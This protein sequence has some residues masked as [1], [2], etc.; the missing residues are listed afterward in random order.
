MQKL[1]ITLGVNGAVETSVFLSSVN[2]SVDV[3]IIAD[4]RCD[5]PLV[6]VRGRT[7]IYGKINAS[8]SFPTM[9]QSKKYQVRRLAYGKPILCHEKYQEFSQGFVINVIQNFIKLHRNGQYKQHY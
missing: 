1:L 5:T 4:A 9:F 3:S 2:A 8:Y 6:T 7:V